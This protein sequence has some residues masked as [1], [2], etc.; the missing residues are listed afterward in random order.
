M[1]RPRMNRRG[2]DCDAPP[3]TE[4]TPD[5]AVFA[6]L[7]VFVRCGQKRSQFDP[8][9]FVTQWKNRRPL[10]ER[11]PVWLDPRKPS[12]AQAV[13]RDGDGRS[14]PP[15]DAAAAKK[16]SC[17]QRG[18]VGLSEA[19]QVRSGCHTIENGTSHQT[20]QKASGWDSIYLHS[21]CQRPKKVNRRF[22]RRAPKRESDHAATGYVDRVFFGLDAWIVGADAIT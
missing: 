2:A 12:V 20:P 1:S 18:S 17:G 11:P 21:G 3:L 16:A 13:I 9:H 6:V 5:H 14:R 19:G 8:E 15:G 7:C 4:A 10:N 22:G